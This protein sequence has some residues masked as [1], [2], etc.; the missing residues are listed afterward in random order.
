MDGHPGPVRAR[1]AIACTLFGGA[2]SAQAPAPAVPPDTV[3]TLE[4]EGCFG[5]CPR[6][7]VSVNA[8]GAVVYEGHDNVRAEG[9]QLDAIPVAEVAALLDE[10][11]RVG[12]L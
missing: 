7:S 6:Y 10:A 1:C 9:A 5:S 12:Y 2:A 3:I 4:R 11:R 8:L